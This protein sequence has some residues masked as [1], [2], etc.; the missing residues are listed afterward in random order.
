VTRP[1][2]H[3]PTTIIA[4]SGLAALL[5]VLSLA[6]GPVRLSPLTVAHALFGGG[7]EEQRIIAQEI[8]LP[9]ALLGLAIG[10]VLGLSG[11]A[12]QGL[13]RNPLAAPSLFGAPQSAAFGAVLVI[14]LGLADVRSFILPLAAIAGAFTSVFLLLV[15][16]GR[17]ANLLLL[18]LAGLAV[19]SLA[20]AATALTMN[21]APNPFIA[22]EIAFWMLGSLE[23]RSFRHVALA[24]PFICAGATL[25]FARRHAFRALTLGE[26]SAQ[27][28][29]VDVARLRLTVIAG[30]ALGVGAA[31]AV[32]GTIGFIGLVAPHLMRPLVGHD[33][34]RLLVPSAL[35]GAALLLAADVAVRII[36]ATSDEIRVGVLTAIIGVPFFLYL[37][38]RERRALGGGLA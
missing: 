5:F 19:S 11:A 34:A 25:L 38:M 3:S 33:P 10:A 13:L 1:S 37:I 31:V 26:E 29:G 17:N 27:S 8:R 23:D 24:L 36:P 30:V 2:R 21:L 12:L 32:A 9:R 28:L 7:N 35:A 14:A 16:A 6:I 20:G 22:L 18:I 15:V 4:L